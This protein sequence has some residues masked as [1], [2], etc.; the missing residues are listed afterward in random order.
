MI[1]FQKRLKLG[2]TL[3]EILIALAIFFIVLTV[4]FSSQV[5]GYQKHK[6]SENKAELVQNAR[7]IIERIV[8]E[9]RQAK[10]IVN[11]LPDD[12]SSA[13][14]SIIFQDGHDTSNIHY[15]R[16]F[17]EGNEIKRMVVAYYF[18]TNPNVYVSWDTKDENGNPPG[19]PDDCEF[20][21]C[22]NCPLTCK[23]LEEP[24][25]IA[26]YINFFRIW[27]SPLVNISISLEKA[28]ENFYIQTKVYARNL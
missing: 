12:E 8:R 11:E 18:L 14:D 26:E 28:T 25:T 6:K 24:R 9:I 21:E 2:F 3:L 15:I 7:I 4:I 16:Y 22:S 23:I 19:G 27:D 10:K 1:F 17:Q 5:L 20:D 13:V